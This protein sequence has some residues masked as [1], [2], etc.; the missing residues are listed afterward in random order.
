VQD[1]KTLLTLELQVCTNL[2][3][4]WINVILEDI[5]ILLL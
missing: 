2:D 3:Y 4:I 1:I 5:H